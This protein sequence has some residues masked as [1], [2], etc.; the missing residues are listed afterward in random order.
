MLVTG[1]PT[2]DTHS[3]PDNGI[4][5]TGANW[6]KLVAIPMNKPFSSSAAHADVMLPITGIHAANAVP[7]T[8][9]WYHEPILRKNVQLRALQKPAN[10]DQTVHYEVIFRFC[11]NLNEKNQQIFL[12]KPI[13]FVLKW[14][15]TDYWYQS[16]GNY[17]H[18]AKSHALGTAWRILLGK[19]ST[20]DW[21]C[22][23]RVR[24][25]DTCMISDRFVLINRISFE[26]IYIQTYREKFSDSS[27][28]NFVKNETRLH[29]ER[30]GQSLLAFVRRGVAHYILH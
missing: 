4:V 21:S 23:Q 19:S 26:K 20:D 7:E 24:F 30:F 2:S 5:N 29:C 13:Y 3:A 18:V 9:C 10:F 1:Q 6:M 25:D 12:Y 8:C 27:H 28:I 14:N 15:L 22:S 11:Q 16:I 17:A